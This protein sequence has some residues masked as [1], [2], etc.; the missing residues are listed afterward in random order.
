MALVLDAGAL[1]AIDKRDAK[2][3]F[4]LRAAQEQ[5][6]PVRTGATAVAQVW[7]DGT[8]QA[9]LARALAGIDVLPLEADGARRVG[10]LLGATGTKDVVDAHVAVLAEPGDRILTSDPKDMDRL[11]DARG[12]RALTVRV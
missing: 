10:E 4:K 11:I 12:V 6:L 8:R 1:I 3:R 9:N 5:A 2:M 7:R